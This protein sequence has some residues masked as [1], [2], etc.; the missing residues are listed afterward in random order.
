MSTTPRLALTEL[1]EN[2]NQS[3]LTWN[4]T[5]RKLDALVQTAVEDDDLT[6][7]PGSPTDGALYI[8]A[9]TATGAWAGKEKYIAQYDNGTWYFYAPFEGMTATI[10][11][12]NVV[13]IYNGTAWADLSTYS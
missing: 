3:Y 7:P 1:Y 2:Q 8:P 6:A 11:D 9:A 13:K 5:L 10:K 4:E 12:E